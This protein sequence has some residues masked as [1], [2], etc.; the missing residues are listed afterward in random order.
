MIQ[1]Y[2]MKRQ[3]GKTT[4]V[5]ALMELDEKL[6]CILPSKSL[7]DF[8]PKHLQ[9]RLIDGRGNIQRQFVG[10]RVA[11]VVLDDGFKYSAQQFASLYYELGRMGVDVISY[12]TV[13]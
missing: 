7:F 13:K 10:R 3:S 6:Y 2:D 9:N 1:V 8:Y 5:K 12:G 4:I 11:R